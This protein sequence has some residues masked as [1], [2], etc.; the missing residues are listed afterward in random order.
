MP[1][2]IR[3]VLASVIKNVAK[4]VKVSKIYLF[5]SYFNGTNTDES[6]VDIAFFIDDNES[7]LDAHRSII[8]ITSRYPIDIQPQIFYE[9]ELLDSSGIVGEIL[10]NGG[11]IFFRQSME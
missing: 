1:A 7:L 8:K 2:D 10:E 9:C 11:E 3:E 5:G 6:D 4:I